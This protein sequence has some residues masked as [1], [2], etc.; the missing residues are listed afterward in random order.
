MELSRTLKKRWIDGKWVETKYIRIQDYD[1]Y[2]VRS[3]LYENYGCSMY[4][5]TWWVTYTG[6]MV[7][8]DIYTHWMLMQ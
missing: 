6:V 2:T 5:E 7:R 1:T 3:W 4:P 8:E